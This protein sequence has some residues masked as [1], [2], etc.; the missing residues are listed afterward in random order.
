MWLFG[1]MCI[2]TGVSLVVAA[3]CR[4]TQFMQVVTLCK[5]YPPIVW[6][7]YSA[8]SISFLILV[9]YEFNFYPFDQ[10]LVV[11]LPRFL[12]Y[13]DYR[14]PFLFPHS[15]MLLPPFF[16]PPS[17]HP[18]LSSSLYLSLLLFLFATGSLNSLNFSINYLL[19]YWFSLVLWLSLTLIPLIFT[20]SCLLFALRLF[21]ACFYSF[22]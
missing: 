3:F 6:N 9:N 19:H 20:I 8:F 13:W 17:I 7:M 4:I 5:H 14:S 11:F 18:S 1:L 21:Y 10:E 15:L 16:L 22:I 2:S 12:V